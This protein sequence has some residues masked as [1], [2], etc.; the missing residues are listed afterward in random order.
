MRRPRS[1]SS[2]PKT[3]V[4]PSLK[5]PPPSR[6]WVIFLRVLLV[7]TAGGYL[8][9][10]FKPV[11]K[12]AIAPPPTAA[13]AVALGGPAQS[14]PG[15]TFN[16]TIGGIKTKRGFTGWGDRPL[17]D[18]SITG[19]E[20]KIKDKVYAQGIGTQAPS[21]IVLALD[22]KVKGFSCLAGVDVRAG[23]VGALSF[24]VLADD[25]KLFSSQVL[26]SSSDPV[27]ISVDVTGAKELRLVVDPAG[28]NDWDQADWVNLKFRK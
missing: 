4:R 16:F 26:K 6:G 15:Q 12:V 19:A 9:W 11:K 17:K 27:T 14:Y 8:A 10:K 25:K 13:P 7:V 1:L 5:V 28:P 3:K 21:E 2:G 20:L 23:D 18:L 22:G 24:I